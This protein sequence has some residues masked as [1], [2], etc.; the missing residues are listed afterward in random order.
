MIIFKEI[1]LQM[2][3][4]DILLIDEN[5]KDSVLIEKHLSNIEEY[6]IK[7]KHITHLQE[8]EEYL[9]HN[10]PS[11]ILLA[12][13]HSV[14]NEIK[15]IRSTVS[16]IPIIVLLKN[17][18]KDL[19]FQSLNSGADDYLSKDF[20]N[21]ELTSRSIRYA[22]ERK[23][24]S[25]KAFESEKK[26]EEL[27]NLLPQT[28]FEIDTTGLLT[29]VN[30]SSLDSFGYTQEDF[31]K[32]LTAFQMIEEKDRARA[33]NNIQ[34]VMMGV[35]NSDNEYIMLRKD[36]STFPALIFSN[37]I[38]QNKKIL[39]LRGIIVEITDRKRAEESLKSSEEKFNLA[40]QSSPISMTI[41][42]SEDVFIDVNDAFLKLT[43]YSREEIIG[44]R[45]NELNLWADKEERNRAQDCYRTNGRVRDYK[46]R[47]RKKS[48]SIGIGIIW[49]EQII[50][51]GEITVLTTTLDITER[52][53]AQQAEHKNREKY[54]NIFDTAPVGIYQST[55][56]GKI[57]SANERLAQILG[58][59]SK[60]ELMQLNLTSDIYYDEDIRENRIS[61]HELKGDVADLELCWKKKD[62]SPIWVQLTAHVITDDLGATQ[63]FEGFVRNVNEQREAEAKL[64]E[65]QKLL[66]TVI[67][68]IPL[69]IWL[70][71]Q[72]GTI[73]HGNSAAQ[74]IWGGAKYVGIEDYGMYKGWFVNNGKKIASREW[75][76]ARAL[77]NGEKIINEE[78]EIESF[79]GIRKTI[80]H[81]A[82]PI[83]NSHKEIFGAIVVNQE[84]SELR[85]K[86]SQIRK[87]SR[88]VEQSPISIVITDTTGIIEYVNPKF[89]QVT[90]YSSSESIGK[91][92]RF[93]KS[94]YTSTETY[95]EMWKT[96]SS[97]NEWRGEFHNVCKNGNKYWE[98]AVISPIKNSMGVITNYLAVKEDISEQKIITSELI[99]AK[100]RAEHS[101]HLKSEFLAQMSHEIRTPLNILLSF[102]TYIREVLE[103]RQHLTDDLDQYFLTTSN[104]GKR[105]IR[106]IEL[107]LNMSDLK[108]GS[109]VNKPQPT[110]IYNDIL[111][112]VFHQFHQS[113]DERKIH[114]DLIQKSD[115]LFANID[116]FATEQLL[117]HIIDNAIKFTEKGHVLIY[118]EKNETG[119]SVIRIE[120][121]GVGIGDDYLKRLFTPF[122]QEDQGYSRSFDGN[123]LGLALVKKYCELNNIRIEIQ[124]EKRKGTIFTLI[125]PN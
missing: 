105:I 79:D 52:I 60:D 82:V 22:F 119:N 88:A 68:T 78:L 16:S 10:S 112:H 77:L 103:E 118:A 85:R 31:T 4:I 44:Y 99:A 56:D 91:N 109:F 115:S 86:D 100:E 72:K 102:S 83:L 49:T 70:V 47:F 14:S 80:L 64:R 81:S 55:R 57:L 89:E 8:A 120:D 124:S 43:E 26:Y 24:N 121:T 69:G 90:G 13:N 33:L 9:L 67:E 34:N 48:G 104:A 37:P 19:V 41:Q 94:G 3:E 5:I 123:G 15:R 59:D 42:N 114:F 125:F 45:G 93:L 98:S 50:I 32:N 66:S 30:N 107:I 1:E 108:S 11:I 46:F 75:G 61:K 38:V 97:G 111:K 65:N 2:L 73:T 71:D 101:D 54:R 106:T 20:L 87:L 113:V 58:Y 39:G 6:S 63:Y 62:G 74:K 36:G 84:I 25:E 117:I 95:I 53:T 51:D 27:V 92:P 7:Y 116:Q 122:T 18:D 35:K 76:A 17:H 12:I 28:V 40:F 29:F 23:T 21:P 110:D 96:L